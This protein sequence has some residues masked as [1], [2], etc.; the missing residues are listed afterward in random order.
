MFSVIWTKLINFLPIPTVYMRIR[1]QYTYIGL[2]VLKLLW[3]EQKKCRL[4]ANISWNNTFP[5]KGLIVDLGFENGKNIRVIIC[6]FLLNRP[7]AQKIVVAKNVNWVPLR[8]ISI[9]FS[10]SNIAKRNE[11]AAL[12]NHNPIPFLSPFGWCELYSRSIPNEF[13]LRK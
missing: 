5:S 4:W 13:F 6:H 1:L 2:N 7:E 8:C 11:V 10:I 12:C 3:T 9:A